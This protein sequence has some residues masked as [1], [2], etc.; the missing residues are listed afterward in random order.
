LFRLYPFISLRLRQPSTPCIRGCDI[1]EQTSSTVSYSSSPSAGR[2][3]W[4]VVI[5]WNCATI[6]LETQD[7][8]SFCACIFALIKCAHDLRYGV[9]I[10]RREDIITINHNKTGCEC[11]SWM[12]LTQDR[13][14]WELTVIVIK[15]RIWGSLSDGYEDRTLHSDKTSCSITERKFWVVG[16]LPTAQGG[17]WSMGEG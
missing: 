7:I 3:A 14:Q 15:C 8:V 1:L 6:S 9:C 13:V 16:W 12:H 10:N 17:Q 5:S 2:N 11:V 4:I